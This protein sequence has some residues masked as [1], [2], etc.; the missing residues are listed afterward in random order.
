MWSHYADLHQ[1]ICI[2]FNTKDLIRDDRIF[3]CLH[4]VVYKQELFDLTPFFGVAP[5]K[6]NPL[7]PTLAACHKATEWCYE[8]EW[9]F[10]SPA[11]IS[12]EQPRFYLSIR[13]KRIIL[14]TRIPDSHKELVEGIARDIR[15][16]VSCATLAND[17][18][19]VVVA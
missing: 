11:G 12:N 6:Q 1:G 7:F 14:G 18:F 5:G 8:R 2:E 9:R 13:P 10:V 19:E 16:S 15:V 3:R 4:P 17:Q